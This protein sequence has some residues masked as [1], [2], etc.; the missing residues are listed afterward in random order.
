MPIP[1]VRLHL[2][3]LFSIIRD[4]DDP[5][6]DPDLIGRTVNITITPQLADR[7]LVPVEG[8]PHGYWP[9]VLRWK[10]GPADDADMPWPFEAL[11]PNL[12][13]P[14]M[15][16]DADRYTI[17]VA[18]TDSPTHTTNRTI[19]SGVDLTPEDTG[20]TVD[21]MPLLPVA[22]ATPTSPVVT[23]P[24]GP[25]GPPG[26]VPVISATATTLAPTDPATAEFTGPPA[27]PLLTLGIP[28]GDKGDPG[29]PTPYQLRGT[30]RP[31]QPAT[32]AGIITGSEAVGTEYVS[33][34][35]A[36]VGAWVWRKRPG[37]TGWQVTDG[38]TGAVTFTGEMAGDFLREPV[39][40]Q[41]IND[42][43]YIVLNRAAVT[44]PSAG[45]VLATPAGWGPGAP[46]QRVYLPGT[47]SAGA[48]QTYRLD[49]V[50]S[51]SYYVVRAATA[52]SSS[53]IQLYGD[54]ATILPW[55]TTL[56]I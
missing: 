37:A 42:R 10:V 21:L 43:I 31:D 46:G 12:A 23:G 53:D 6:D 17:V 3:E 38:D 13:D 11:V 19:S 8:D 29:N 33:T 30:G 39:T 55:P 24:E 34:D 48:P 28:Q 52:V 35:G 15:L 5:G 36:G 44:V 56:T 14:A 25:E 20:T 26:P 51:G 50:P 41:R 18:T 2:D 47:V 9:E 7:A 49:T 32:T 40:F 1:T 27:T 22:A 16:T 4:S 45:N 54:W